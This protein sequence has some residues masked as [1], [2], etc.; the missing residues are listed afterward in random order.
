MYLEY[1]I[2]DT[3]YY[4]CAYGC[5]IK[6]SYVHPIMCNLIEIS[7]IMVT[8]SLILICFKFA[9]REKKECEICKRPFKPDG[10]RKYTCCQK[11]SSARVRKLAV[12]KSLKGGKNNGKK[13]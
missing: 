11:C 13:I 12:M 6:G 8:V 9:K 4:K 1:I 7:L 3:Y 2:P 5:F 10:R